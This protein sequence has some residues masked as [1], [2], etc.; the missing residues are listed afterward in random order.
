MKKQYIEPQIEELGVCVCD[1]ICTSEIEKSYSTTSEGEITT[2]DSRRSGFSVW[3][4]E[5]DF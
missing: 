4:D 2:A 1:L 3:D 5:E